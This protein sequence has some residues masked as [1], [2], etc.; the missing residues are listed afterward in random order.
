MRKTTM[1]LIT[2][3]LATASAHAQATD[4]RTISVSGVFTSQIQPDKINWTVNI[5]EFGTELAVV[6][7]NADAKV[8][9]V[10]DTIKGLGIPQDAIQTGYLNIHRETEPDVLGRLRIKGWRLYR[11]ITF[12]QTDLARFDEFF[13]KLAG[14]AEVEVSY[15]FESSK[16]H[17]T[18]KETRLQAIRM[19]KEKAA[20]MCAELGVTLGVAQT[21]SE[22]GNSFAGG[23]PWV[24][25]RPAN[26]A[27]NGSLVVNWA[28]QPPDMVS[29]SMFPGRIDIT[30]SV[31]V[32][33]QIQ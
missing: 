22:S 11:T 2:V 12:T 28:G 32:T 26:P 19:A 33:F 30:E 9:T 10:L 16:C 8:K 24:P 15:S 6:K 4:L 14:S 7:A 27:S 13:D 1:I 31:S 29:G 25:D 3:L 5:N 17:E 23:A 21:V 20:A 18:R